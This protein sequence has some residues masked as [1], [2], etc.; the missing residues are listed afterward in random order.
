M[1]YYKMSE[2]L[3]TLRCHPNDTQLFEDYMILIKNWLNEV[4]KYSYSIE[5]DDTINRHLHLMIKADYRDADKVRRRLTTKEFKSIQI[6]LNKSKT[7]LKSALRIDKVK[8]LPQKA[9]GYTQKWHCLRRGHSGYTDQEIVDAVEFYYTTARLEKQQDVSQDW[10]HVTNKN[11]HAIV[12]DFVKKDEDI[13]S[14]KD[15]DLIKLKMVKSKH[16][17]QL[18]NKDQ[19]RYFKELRIAHQDCSQHDEA[20]CSQEAYGC[21]KT[22]DA[23]MVD[24]IKDLFKYIL[25]TVDNGKDIPNNIYTMYK[26][27]EY[28][29]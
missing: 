25:S 27:Y 17:F 7:I 3:I 29:H 5:W 21:D 18:N 12:E 11:F 1:L 14:F 19:E 13:K 26:K 16:T 2:F 28:L 4:E 6:N 22:F 10:I 9:L 24:D 8:E 20:S 15:S 23:Y